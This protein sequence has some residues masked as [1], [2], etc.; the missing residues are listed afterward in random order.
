MQPEQTFPGLCGQTRPGLIRRFLPFVQCCRKV[1][2]GSASGT[3]V[4]F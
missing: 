1:H 4:T 2:E 3:V